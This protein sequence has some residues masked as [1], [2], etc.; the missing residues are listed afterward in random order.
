[1]IVLQ[2]FQFFLALIVPGLIGAVAYSIVV[3]LKTKCNWCVAL[4]LD[5]LTFT[6]M[7]TGLYF[8]KHVT[9]IGM[10]LGEFGCL[11]FTRKYILLSILITIFL[12]VG[13]GFIRKCFFWIRRDCD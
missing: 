12:G 4:I 7:I 2:F 5:L 10:L 8:F 9:T 13:I 6:I 11:S 3:C 1:M